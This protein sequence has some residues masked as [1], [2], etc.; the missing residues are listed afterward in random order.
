MVPEVHCRDYR[1]GDF[2]AIQDLWVSTHVTSPVRGDDEAA[3]E[4]TLA[5]GGRLLVLEEPGGALAGAAWITCDGRRQYLHHFA[6]RPA[7]QGRGLGRG[8]LA[9]V[10]ALARAVGLQLKLEVYRS[11]ARAQDLYRRSG[12]T[13]PGDM[14]VLMMRE[15]T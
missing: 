14:D 4:R 11:N 10:L 5:M 12:F 7:L 1:P 15:F 8:L 13:S 9:E 2:P 6:I 3:V